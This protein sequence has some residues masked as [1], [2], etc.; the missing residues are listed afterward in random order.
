MENITGNYDAL[1]AAAEKAT[2]GSWIN[3]G[4]WVE[5]EHDDLKDI[6][7]CRPNGN[8]DYEQALRDAAYIAL[9][10]PD[11]ILRL[12]RERRT[13]LT[14]ASG[15]P[16]YASVAAIQYALDAEEG[17]EWLSLW[18]EGEFERCRRDW[19]DAP[20]DCYIG[21]D[22]MHPETQRLL[23]AHATHDGEVT[24]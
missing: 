5:N 21:A 12:L 13:A 20:D 24:Q 3:V 14:A 7:D 16:T 15:H 18:N 1:Q 10:N 4:A 19:P 11:T 9:A 2:K 8:E 6:C 23:A 22:P 17:F